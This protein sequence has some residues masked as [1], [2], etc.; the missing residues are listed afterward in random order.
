MKPK[1]KVAKNTS[2]ILYKLQNGKL[3]LLDP[4]N[5]TI[6]EKQFF[7]NQIVYDDY[8]DCCFYDHTDHPFK[9]LLNQKH[10]E[11]LKFIHLHGYV[12]LLRN[13]VKSSD[14]YYFTCIPSNEIFYC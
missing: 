6:Q 14:T 7:R 5:I 13:H 12:I 4:Y 1:Y 11:R 8:I 9:E 2:N 10:L 3:E